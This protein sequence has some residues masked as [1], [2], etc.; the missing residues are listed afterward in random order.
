MNVHC[1]LRTLSIAYFIPVD[2]CACA[3]IVRF[4]NGNE[5]EVFVLYVE[6]KFV[7]L[8]KHSNHNQRNVN[9]ISKYKAKVK[10]TLRIMM[11]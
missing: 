6:M 11:K 7:M 3:T 9:F 4:I 8:S 10:Q 2:I 5:G 1:V